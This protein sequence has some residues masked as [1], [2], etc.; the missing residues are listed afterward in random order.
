M[1]MEALFKPAS[2]AER[3][4]ALVVQ[5]R[6]LVVIIALLVGC[7]VELWPERSAPEATENFL[8]VPSGR[9]MTEPEDSDPITAG[10]S[11]VAVRVSAAV[12]FGSACAA[13]AGGK[14]S[15]TADG[16]GLTRKGQAA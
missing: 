1:N 9:A 7:I 8:P 2:D 16:R 13:P 11:F 10:A 4:R 5:R 3:V 6:W 12:A 14:N 15:S